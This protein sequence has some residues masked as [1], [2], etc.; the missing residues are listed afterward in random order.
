[1]ASTIEFALVR[2]EL[3]DCNTGKRFP[4]DLEAKVVGLRGSF[5]PEAY[6]VSQV[7]AVSDLSSLPDTEYFLKYHC[8]GPHM[9]AVHDRAEG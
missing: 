6:A 5:G 8:H 2:G 1:M 3:E 7:R 4:V 9:A